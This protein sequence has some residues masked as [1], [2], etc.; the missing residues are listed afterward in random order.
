[1]RWFDDITDAMD[2]NL[3]KHRGIV[4]DKETWHA[5]VHVV[6]ESEMTWCLDNNNNI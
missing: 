1:M 2:M 3:G 4:R 6:A 5:A